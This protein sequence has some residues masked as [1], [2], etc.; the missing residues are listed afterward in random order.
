MTPEQRRQSAKELRDKGKTFKEIGI[1]LNVCS[2]RAR[3]LCKESTN[4]IHRF[5][6]STRCVNG[7]AWILFNK[8]RIKF[9]DMENIEES[10]IKRIVLSFDLKNNKIKFLGKKSVQELLKWAES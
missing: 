9:D 3:E 1:A 8:C 10:D 6:L 4:S 5:G 7:I 2:T